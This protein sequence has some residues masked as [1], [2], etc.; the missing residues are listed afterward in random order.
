MG[1]TTDE[2]HKFVAAL[3]RRGW[4]TEGDTVWTPSRGLWFSEA[5]FRDWTVEEF[6]AIF[7]RRADRI[8]RAACEH[9]QE[10]ARENRDASQAAGELL[11]E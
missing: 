6:Q 11:E 7:T 1:M 5:H 3:Q 4:T 9:W 10:S 2:K 8:E